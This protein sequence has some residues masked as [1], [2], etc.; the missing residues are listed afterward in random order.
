MIPDSQYKG[1]GSVTRVLGT[2]TVVFTIVVVVIRMST[3]VCQNMSTR[4]PICDGDTINVV[5]VDAICSIKKLS[6]E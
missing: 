4:V 3:G 5:G 1:R 6:G 2:G